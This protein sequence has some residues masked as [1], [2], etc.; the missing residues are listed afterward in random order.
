[1]IGASGTSRGVVLAGRYELVREIASGGMAEVW[2]GHAKSIGDFER[3]VAIKCCHPHLRKDAEFVAMFLDEA[4]LAAKIHHPNV[5]AT[6]DV[7]DDPQALFLVMEYVEGAT[8]HELVRTEH[9]RH[10]C[11]PPD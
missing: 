1:M 4:R 2:L 5:V 9:D 6:L 3:R 10:R 7:V 8:L 11:V